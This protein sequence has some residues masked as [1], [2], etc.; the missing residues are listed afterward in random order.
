MKTTV[1]A[2]LAA[3]LKKIVTEYPNTFPLQGDER[4]FFDYR[5]KK[6][7]RQGYLKT[8]TLDSL[9]KQ[10]GLS[11]LNKADS[12]YLEDLDY[13]NFTEMPPEMLRLVPSLVGESLGIKIHWFSPSLQ[14]EIFPMERKL[15]ELHGSQFLGEPFPQNRKRS[16]LK[17]AFPVALILLLLGGI[18]WK[19]R[20]FTPVGG[21]S[22][23]LAT[24]PMKH[25]FL[26]LLR[27]STPEVLNATLSTPTVRASLDRLSA[28]VPKD[29]TMY[30]IHLTTTREEEAR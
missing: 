27:N 11:R 15:T 6:M 3:D 14:N 21:T 9:R 12:D 19:L 4:L 22:P 17:I 8:A 13:D 18:G 26:P 5:L 29:G 24:F 20:S 30:Q 1:S 10:L 7:F 28:A 23:S 25:S 16:G 2:D